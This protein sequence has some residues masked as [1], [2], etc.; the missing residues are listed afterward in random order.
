[1]LWVVVGVVVLGAV[2]MVGA[3]LGSS[4]ARSLASDRARRHDLDLRAAGPRTMTTRS[5]R[6]LFE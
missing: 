3:L 4:V 6:S 1:M 2:F 5:A